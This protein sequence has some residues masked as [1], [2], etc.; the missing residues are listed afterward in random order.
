V[1]VF[2]RESYP[3]VIQER[4]T[5]LDGSKVGLKAGKVLVQE[6]KRR[7]C[8]GGMDIFLYYGGDVAGVVWEGA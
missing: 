6:F 4:G 3:N 7:V 2:V 8:C 5:L 1:E